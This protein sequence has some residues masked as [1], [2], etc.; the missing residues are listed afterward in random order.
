MIRM[1]IPLVVVFLAYLFIRTF[2]ERPQEPPID[3]DPIDASSESA[4]AAASSRGASSAG[5][6]EGDSRAQANATQDDDIIDVE[7]V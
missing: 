4:D 3:I 2:L 6:R 5:S 7:P 1:L